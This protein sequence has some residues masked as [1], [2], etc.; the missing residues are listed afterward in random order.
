M[1]TRRK[2]DLEKILDR[3]RS[4]AKRRD[5][6]KFHTPKNLV[7]GLVGEVGELTELFQWLSDDE[8]AAIMSDGAEAEKVRH[9]LA[10]VFYYLIRLADRLG[11]DLERAFWEKMRINERKYPAA[12]VKGISKKY[13]CLARAKKARRKNTK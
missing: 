4:F 10:D 7:M 3:Q 9:E 1:S 12:L 2:L 8:A 13:D 6:E 11:I 5:W